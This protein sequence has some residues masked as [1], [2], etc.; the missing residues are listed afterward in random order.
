MGR[1][2]QRSTWDCLMLAL[3]V[4]QPGVIAWLTP[5]VTEEDQAGL[6]T[7]VCADARSIKKTQLHCCSWAQSFNLDVL[8]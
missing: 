7:L 1:C 3:A 5:L 6:L 4:Y 8:R 2:R